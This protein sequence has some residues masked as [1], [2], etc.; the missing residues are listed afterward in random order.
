M[1]ALTRLA[2]DVE[3]ALMLA[4]D[5]IGDGK[6]QADAFAF[7]FG[8]KE[9]LE[10]LLHILFRD[11]HAGITDLNLDN[12]PLPVKICGNCKHSTF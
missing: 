7:V 10:N 6:S 3:L 5:T 2:L 4:D 12:I 9:G 11:A 1:N 8:S